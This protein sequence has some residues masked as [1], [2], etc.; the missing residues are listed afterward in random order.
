[1]QS[2]VGTGPRPCM[3]GWG[4]SP[5]QRGPRLGLC[6]GT[7]SAQKRRLTDTTETI[8]SFT[9]LVGGSVQILD[10]LAVMQSSVDYFPTLVPCVVLEGHLGIHHTC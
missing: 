1:M 3:R 7:P 8:T 2:G 4:G 5:M 9:L 10:P 6:T